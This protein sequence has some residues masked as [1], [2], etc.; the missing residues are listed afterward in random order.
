MKTK[1]KALNIALSHGEAIK[2][3]FK[4]YNTQ[5]VNDM[6][7]KY[8]VSRN[9]FLIV[10]SLIGL[11]STERASNKAKQILKNIENSKALVDDSQLDR[12]RKI[13]G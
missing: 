12:L 2:K 11:K 13:V 1:C 6:S 3:D 9:T 8:G 10:L 5:S 4:F 7:K